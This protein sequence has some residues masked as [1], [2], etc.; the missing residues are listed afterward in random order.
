MQGS[1]EDHGHSKPHIDQINCCLLEFQG[2]WSVKLVHLPTERDRS[3]V[4]C[5]V[6]GVYMSDSL[7]NERKPEHYIVHHPTSWQW[8]FGATA[9]KTEVMRCKEE[10][11]R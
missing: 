2:K 11:L 1:V 9:D 3:P 4:I 6:N 5:H 8:G 7:R 10:G